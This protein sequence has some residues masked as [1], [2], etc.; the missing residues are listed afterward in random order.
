MRDAEVRAGLGDVHLVTLHRGVVGV[1]AVVRDLPGEVRG[2]EEGVGDEADH[3]VDELV[4]GEGRV[5][6][7]VADDPD[8]G[9]DETLEPPAVKLR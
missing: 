6:A 9:E 5:T 2:P 8:T 7:L 3:I 1:V 4:S